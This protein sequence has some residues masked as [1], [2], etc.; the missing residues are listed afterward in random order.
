MFKNV[1]FQSKS[2]NNI[3]LIKR[4]IRIEKQNP[5]VLTTKNRNAMKKIG[6]I[7][8]LTMP[9]ISFKMQINN[10]KQIPEQTC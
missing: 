3:G 8:I 6:S 9:K 7:P 5:I 10:L 4:L 2:H 1:F